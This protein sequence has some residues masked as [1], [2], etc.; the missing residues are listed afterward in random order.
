MLV[1]KIGAL[2]SALTGLKDGAPALQTAVDDAETAL[3]DAED[4]PVGLGEEV[5]HGVVRS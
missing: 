2:T 1:D 4:V 3:A 5:V